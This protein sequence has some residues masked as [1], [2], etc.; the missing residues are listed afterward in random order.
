MGIY[1]TYDEAN[2][3]NREGKLWWEYMYK[4]RSFKTSWAQGWPPLL[5]GGEK[6]FC[7]YCIYA[8][9]VSDFFKG[10]SSCRTDCWKAHEF[11]SNRACSIDIYIK[12]NHLL[13][14]RHSRSKG[15]GCKIK[16]EEMKRHSDCD[17]EQ[18]STECRESGRECFRD[19]GFRELEC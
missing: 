10:S 16:D 12:K 7:K 15:K 17:S 19:E 2:S 5:H 4:G 11:R 13:C 1:T 6:M 14:F 3:L 9:V 18:S 8:S